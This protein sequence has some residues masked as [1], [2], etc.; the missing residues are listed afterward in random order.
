MAVA[1]SE[2]RLP[3]VESPME[4]EAAD[5]PPGGVEA[6]LSCFSFNQDCT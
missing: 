4:A 6:A 3:R 2:L 5:G 1:G